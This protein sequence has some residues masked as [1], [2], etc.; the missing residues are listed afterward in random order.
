MHEDNEAKNPIARCASCKKLIFDD[1]YNVY[2]N[3]D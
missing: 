1:D 3:N 2:I